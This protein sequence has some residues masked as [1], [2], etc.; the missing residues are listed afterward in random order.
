MLPVARELK[1]NSKLYLNLPM[2]VNLSHLLTG[3]INVNQSFCDMLG[4]PLEELKNK[5]WQDITPEDEIPVVQNNLEPLLKGE[6]DS[7]GSKN[8]TS[9]KTGKYIWADVS[10]SIRRDSRGEP[11]YFITTVVDITERKRAELALNQS[12]DRLFRALENIPDV[13]VIYDKELK[14]QFING[15]ARK[16]T[17]RPESDF[18]GKR[19]EEIWSQE[20][21]QA[22]LP[23]L[24]ESFNTGEV[25]SLD[26]ELTFPNSD[27]RNLRITCVPLLDEKGV[28]KEIMGITNDFTDRMQVEKSL[29]E[30]DKQY[31]SLFENMN[32][33]FVLFEVVTDDLGATVDLIVSAANQ[34]FSATTGVE[35]K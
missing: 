33:G 14:I 9:V 13:V 12:E 3:E 34:G 28:V 17:G 32:A 22:Y 27:T 20:V 23:M 19:E 26:I 1:K 2:L 21:Y 7:P 11:L 15:A 16:V 5:K 8:D 30:S 25:R 6:K 29:I 31:R 18:L 10:V 4:Y 35:A 24:K